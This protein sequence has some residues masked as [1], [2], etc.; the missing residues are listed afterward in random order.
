MPPGSHPVQLQRSTGDLGNHCQRHLEEEGV[1]SLRFHE[2]HPGPADLEAVVIGLGGNRE[3]V[4]LW[5]EA[6][7]RVLCMCFNQYCIQKDHRRD[8]R[9]CKG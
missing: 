6:T 1:V 8:W 3:T 4:G 2:L 7:K 5:E 9:E